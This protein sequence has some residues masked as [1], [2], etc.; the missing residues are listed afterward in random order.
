MIFP[1]NRDRENR[2]RTKI[3]WLLASALGTLFLGYVFSE[4]ARD[5]DVKAQVAK[6]ELQ[7]DSF[8][9]RMKTEF[10]EIE[11]IAFFLDKNNLL[12]M[13][14][15]FKTN[16]KQTITKTYDL[17]KFFDPRNRANFKFSNEGKGSKYPTDIVTMP[18]NTFLLYDLIKE[19]VIEFRLKQK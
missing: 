15:I 4:K 9:K 19:E 17:G 1:G 5:Q 14:I 10:P 6:I 11:E 8:V 7:K 3:G 12:Q 13:S 18:R 16:N 2:G